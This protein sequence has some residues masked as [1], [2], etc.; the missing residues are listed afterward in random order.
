MVRRDGT[1]TEARLARLGELISLLGFDERRYSDDVQAVKQMSYLESINNAKEIE[2]SLQ[3]QDDLRE[4]WKI[5]QKLER[6]L[7]EKINVARIAFLRA[8]AEVREAVNA[9]NEIESLRN[10]KP[11]LFEDNELA[12]SAPEPSEPSI[13][14]QLS[15]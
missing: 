6:S 12:E 13:L 11:Y 4:E 1:H 14:D 8:S 9:P 7:P 2:N 3:T 10:L 5:L 15:Q